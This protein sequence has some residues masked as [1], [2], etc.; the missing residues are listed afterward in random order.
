M[1]F[2]LIASS[3]G[4][5]FSLTTLLYTFLGA[6]GGILIGSI[7]GLT[8]TMGI[9]LLV[10]FTY[11]L[12][13][14]SGVAMLLG[15][16]CGGMYGG[17]ISAILIHTPGTPAAA[18]TVL[19]GYPMGQRGEAG[20]AL[21]ISLFS[22]FVGGIIGA[23]IMTFL[24]PYI[25]NM[26]LKFGPAEFF[27]LAIFGLSVIVSISGKS[28]IK[29][30]ISACFGLLIGCV[31]IDK[32]C[33][34]IRFF[35]FPGFYD[36]IPFIPALIGLFAVSEVLANFEHL[37]EGTVPEKVQR[38]YKTGNA[39]GNY[40]KSVVKNVIPS[41]ADFKVIWPHMIKGG[42]IGT[43]IGA[44]PGAG[45][46]I[47]A[48][49]SYSEA[50]RTSKHPEKFGH[51]A[52]EGV[53]AAE[54]AN[55]GCS[56]GAMIPLLALGV[57]GDSNTAVLMG[58]FIMHGF[59][60]GPMMYVEHLNIVYAVFGALLA[61]NLA[62]LVVGMLGVNLFSKVINIQRY[63]LIPCILVL[64]LVGSY[65]INQSMFDVFF[66]I[67]MGVV[68][69]LLQKYGFSLSPILLSLI[70]GP[71]SE[72]NLRRYMQIVDGNFFKIFSRPICLLFFTLAILSLITAVL[73]QR[74]IERNERQELESNNKV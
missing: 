22:S 7:P 10:P 32:T 9:A 60:P 4:Q 36:G 43:F 53:A 12:D 3:F 8:A 49:V 54:S 63:I 6:V 34:Y 19:E 72:S 66:A 69:Y 31:G 13:F 58:A 1:D 59:Q 26:A 39:I 50:K 71:M 11:G 68:G 48:F 41:L 29:G 16:F 62:F 14:V 27:A 20:R 30:L 47:A 24:S 45:G 15:I 44:I 57:P 38:T 25:S 17:S 21:T 28:I 5:V 67:V 52:P 70:L 37:L 42:L 33:G 73:N 2:S 74:K 46:D 23:L 61:A 64:S 56:G 65:A 51:G 55:N 40:L 35:T 18:A